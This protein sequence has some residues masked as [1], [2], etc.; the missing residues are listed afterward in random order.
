MNKLRVTL[1]EARHIHAT[2]KSHPLL[3]GFET[4]GMSQSIWHKVHNHAISQGYKYHAASPTE[5]HYYKPT[6]VIK[7]TSY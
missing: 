3:N 5:F 1:H 4:F 6:T 7:F 2:T